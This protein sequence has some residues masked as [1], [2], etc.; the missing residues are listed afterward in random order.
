MEKRI[1]SVDDVD[2]NLQLIKVIFSRK[3]YITSASDGLEA[4]SKLNSMPENHVGLV[5]TDLMMP[6]LDGFGLL[7]KIRESEKWYN[8]LPVI[9][10]S[11]N[12]AKGDIIRWN[13]LGG[14]DYLTKLIDREILLSIV[15]NRY[16][17]KLV[18]RI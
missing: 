5:L 10:I 18:D 13:S 7:Q 12:S 3:Y 6:H 15:D 9:A 17:K 4:I 2:I 11:T 1:L 16:N 14:T 8:S